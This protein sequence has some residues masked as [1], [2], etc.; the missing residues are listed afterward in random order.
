MLCS[1]C[2]KRRPLPGDTPSGKNANNECVSHERYHNLSTNMF[3][4][5]ILTTLVISVALLSNSVLAGRGRV[6]GK[7]PKD[8]NPGGGSGSCTSNC[9][10]VFLND[11]TSYSVEVYNIHKSGYTFDSSYNSNLLT[12]SLDVSLPGGCP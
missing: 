6:K 8:D 12:Q 4:M 5:K 7:P 9:L 11:I 2:K 3:S 1:C 10:R